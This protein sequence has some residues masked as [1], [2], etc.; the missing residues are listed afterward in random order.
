MILM[1]RALL[2]S[3]VFFPVSTQFYFADYH[4]SSKSYLVQIGCQGF[5]HS[6]H[7]QVQIKNLSMT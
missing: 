3:T 5:E 1:L 7:A 4:K 2:A 6:I